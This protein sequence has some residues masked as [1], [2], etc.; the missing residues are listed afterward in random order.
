MDLDNIKQ[1]WSGF[2]QSPSVEEYKIEQILKNEGRDA[3]SRLIR[4]EKIFL[5]LLL[6]CI[7]FGVMVFYMHHLT[8][9]FFA[10]SLIVAFLWQMH[11]IRHLKSIDILVM[12]VLSVSKNINQYR[13]YIY[14]EI[15]VGTLFAPIF[16]ACYT[17]FALPNVLSENYEGERIIFVFVFSLIL[18]AVI[19]FVIYKKLYINNIRFLQS[20]I[21]E[22]AEFE[23]NNV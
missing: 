16:F 8:G 3:L 10:T 2:D 15:I 14:R 13:K 18:Y 1:T 9:I 4:Y 11:K 21:K 17:F 20:S 19:T 23:K 6:P 22:V 12:D 5:W 7:G